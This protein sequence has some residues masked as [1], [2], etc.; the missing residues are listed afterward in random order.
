LLSF[1]FFWGA[2]A[3]GERMDGVLHQLA[4]CLVNQAMAGDG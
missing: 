4:E 3:D 1:R 2:R